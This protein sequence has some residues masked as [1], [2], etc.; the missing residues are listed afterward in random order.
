MNI[1]N[2][3]IPEVQALIAL[4]AATG[5][6]SHVAARRVVAEMHKQGFGVTFAPCQGCRAVHGSFPLVSAYH[7]PVCKAQGRCAECGAAMT[8]IG[9]GHLV[10]LICEAC[11]NGAALHRSQSSIGESR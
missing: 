1:D 9:K 3:S 7:S 2:H 8:E 5:G 4:I 6:V 11:A 10:G